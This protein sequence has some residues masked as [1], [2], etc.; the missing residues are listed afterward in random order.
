MQLARVYA[1]GG[2]GVV[3]TAASLGCCSCVMASDSRGF[4][5]WCLSC[6]VAL[7]F[8]RGTLWLRMV[9]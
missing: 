3:R 6:R 5:M 1:V 4:G 2:V 9:A 8:A 7:S